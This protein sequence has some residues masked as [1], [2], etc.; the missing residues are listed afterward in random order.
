[1]NKPLLILL[2]SIICMGMKAQ[3]IAQWRGASRNGNYTESGLLKKWPESGPKLLWHFKELGDGHTS[4]AI[5]GS[6]VFT[7]GMLNGTGY[8]FAFNNDGKLLWKK[9]YGKEWSVNWDGTRSTPLIIK[10]KLFVMSSFGKLVCMNVSNGNIIW[11]IE[12]QKQY[13]GRNIEWG[14]TENLL[15]DGNTLYCCPGGIEANVIALDLNTGKLLWKSKGNGEKSAYGS[16]LLISLSERK[17]IVAMME[18]SIQGIDA[19]TGK[20]LWKHPQPNQYSVHPNVPVFING[21]LYC[22]SGYGQGGVMLKLSDD[23]SSVTELWRNKSLDPRMGGVVAFDSKIFGAGDNTRKLLC[24][25]WNSGKELYSI[26]QLAPSNI[27]ANDG[28]LYVYSERGIVS[29]VEP[30]ADSFNIISSFKVPFGTAQ[31]WAHL[32]IKNKRLYVRHGT[33]LMVY[34]LASS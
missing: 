21:N 22:T 29:L 27:I 20:F 16:P 13:D 5:T 19:A 11:N 6:G 32:V 4:A 23:G 15:F 3:E 9:E 18:N 17:I 26:N 24:I 25:D 28:L 33:S 34:D 2:I 1:M 12:L 14:V 8:V 10:D 7:T 31:H 30:K